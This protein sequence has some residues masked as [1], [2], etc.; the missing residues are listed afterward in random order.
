M[1]H[2]MGA[3]L[4]KEGRLLGLDYGTK[5]LG[6]AVCDDLQIIASPLENYSRYSIEA[7]ELFLKQTVKEYRIIGIVVGLPVHMS[8]DEGGKATRGARVWSLGCAG[9]RLSCRLP[10]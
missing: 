1:S 7:D 6:V 9:H 4:P 5:R 10:R 8:G 3:I 2:G